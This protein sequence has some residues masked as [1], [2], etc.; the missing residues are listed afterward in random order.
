MVTP[1]HPLDQVVKDLTRKS[2]LAYSN[3]NRRMFNGR[4]LSLS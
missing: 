2:L 1:P 3:Q 4:A